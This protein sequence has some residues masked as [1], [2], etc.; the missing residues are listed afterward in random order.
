MDISAIGGTSH[1]DPGGDGT[2][3]PHDGGAGMGHPQPG[4]ATC[5]R[6]ATHFG[7]QDDRGRGEAGAAEGLRSTDRRL[8]PRGHRY[9]RMAAGD[10][11]RRP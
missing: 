7:W 3:R 10:L 1:H 6:H 8:R 5:R 4:T 9:S 2:F 11:G